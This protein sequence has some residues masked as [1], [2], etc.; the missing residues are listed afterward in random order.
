MKYL[1]CYRDQA[2]GDAWRNYFS[3]RPDIEIVS[4][5]ICSLACDAIVSPANSFGFMDGGLDH[6]LSEHFGWGLEKQVQTAIGTRPLRELLVGEAI[7]EPTGNSAIPWLIVA[8]TMRIPMPI[9]TTINAYLAM[10]A[11]LIAVR[12]HSPCDFHRCRSDSRAR[13]GGWSACAGTLR[14]ANVAG[15]SRSSHGLAGVSRQLR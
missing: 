3:G 2:L 8:P 14:V 9:R 5:D 12:E 11:V 10:K 15:F 4:G 7:I 1:L 6:Q 13:N